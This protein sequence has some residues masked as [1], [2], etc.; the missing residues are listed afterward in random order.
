MYHTFGCVARA[1]RAQTSIGWMVP[2]SLFACMMLMRI[3]PRDCATQGIPVNEPGAVQRQIRGAGTSPA[4]TA[5]VGA[6]PDCRG[7]G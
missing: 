5:G 3:V 2:T 1:N 7:R 6:I 4:K